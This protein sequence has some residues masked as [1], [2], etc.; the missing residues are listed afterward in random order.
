MLAAYYTAFPVHTFSFSYSFSCALILGA[1]DQGSEWHFFQGISSA[2]EDR[3]QDFQGLDGPNTT[4]GTHRM[5][6]RLFSL[7]SRAKT[8]SGLLRLLLSCWALDVVQSKCK[9]LPGRKSKLRKEVSVVTT[10]SHALS[11]IIIHFDD[12]VCKCSTSRSLGMM[13]GSMA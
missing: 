2:Q 6:M 4:L 3:F 5:A 12:T 8:R 11:I 7:P 13:P 9:Q 1:C 10:K